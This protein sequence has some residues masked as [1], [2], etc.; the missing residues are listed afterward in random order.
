M[1]DLGVGILLTAVVTALMVLAWGRVALIPGL[2]FG[3]LATAIHL[4]AVALLRPALT[5][6]YGKLMSR[7]GMGMGLRLVG[8]A[9][10]ALAVVREP[11]VFPAL[12]T[13]VGYMG[14]LIPLLFFEMRLFR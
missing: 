6:S 11:G 10:F 3:L 7:W 13:A 9:L 14:V 2:S 1:K 12:P 8:V 4:T 5:G